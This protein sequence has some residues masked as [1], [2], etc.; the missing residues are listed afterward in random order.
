MSHPSSVLKNKLPDVNTV[1]LRKFLDEG[2]AMAIVDQKKTDPFQSFL[3][4]INK[5]DIVV[6]S[7]K[8]H[9]ECILTLSGRYKADYFKSATHT[10]SVDS[11]VHDVYLGGKT[12]P[13]SPKSRLEKTLGGSKRKNKI[14]LKLDEHVFIDRNDQMTLDRSG[15]PTTY[16]FKS[17]QENIEN[18]PQRILKENQPN[19][20]KLEITHD[21]AIQKLESRLKQSL[22][23]DIR[24]LTDE[25]ILQEISEVYIPIFEARLT[26]PKQK[27]GVLRIDA[28]RKKIL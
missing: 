9:Y 17:D 24:D 7:M 27:A 14:D 12:F 1:A 20:Q 2:D 11:N 18:Y 28:A 25:F 21:T 23:T 4:R 26:G 5:D 10:I 16:S 8:L 3:S 13:A 15:K 22:D 19:I 6:D